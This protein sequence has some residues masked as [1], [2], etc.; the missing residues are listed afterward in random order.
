M[1]VAA[2]QQMSDQQHR[3]YLATKPYYIL[4]RCWGQFR[5]TL[6]VTKGNWRWLGEMDRGMIDSPRQTVQHLCRSYPRL[7]DS[8]RDWLELA[9][10]TNGGRMP[11]GESFSEVYCRRDSWKRMI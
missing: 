5:D 1:S 4:G 6:V 2:V 7:A 10:S 3:E 11:A 8:F 9:E